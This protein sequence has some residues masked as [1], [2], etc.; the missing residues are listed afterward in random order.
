MPFYFSLQPVLRLRASYERM[1]R[2]RLLGIVAAIVQVREEIAAVERESVSARKSTQSR[3]GA[4]VAGVELH[5][6]LLAENI[7]VER[8]RVLGVRL[9]EFEKKQEIQ[10]LA[11]RL[12][13]QKREI[14]VNLR[15]R[16]WEEYRRVQARRDQQRLDELYLLHGWA[17]AESEPD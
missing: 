5:F 12:A 8:R 10:R 7:R 14:L 2:L 6:E 16:K 13:R 11:Y 4:G 3:L 17:T 1:E 9:V 15:Q